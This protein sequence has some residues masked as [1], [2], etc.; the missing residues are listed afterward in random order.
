[1]CPSLHLLT[2]LYCIST[3]YRVQFTLSD[4]FGN[5]F[6]TCVSKPESSPCYGL[7]S[8]CPACDSRTF[9]SSSYTVSTEHWALSP[10]IGPHSTV[11]L[12]PLTPVTSI[13]ETP[14]LWGTAGRLGVIWPLVHSAPCPPP[15]CLA[16]HR[17]CQTLTETWREDP[18]RRLMRERRGLD[19]DWQLHRGPSSSQR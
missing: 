5:S 8:W 15:S 16:P 3:L 1:M 13:P 2:V 7:I 11:S 12:W 10:L 4:P 9:S 14:L 19:S 17:E 18:E 6:C